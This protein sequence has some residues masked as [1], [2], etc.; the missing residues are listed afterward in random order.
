MGNGN[1]I[2]KHIFFFFKYP[3]TLIR[4]I[5]TKK[6]SP[7]ESRERVLTVFVWEK[8]WTEW[9]KWYQIYIK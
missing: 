1:T 8:I 6:N 4:V 5:T 3:S 2:P 9:K 7:K